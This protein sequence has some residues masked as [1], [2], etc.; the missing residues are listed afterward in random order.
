MMKDPYSEFIISHGP[1]NPVLSWYANDVEVY[2]QNIHFPESLTVN[3]RISPKQ[4]NEEAKYQHKPWD[5]PVLSVASPSKCQCCSYPLFTSHT[6]AYKPTLRQCF[7]TC[8]LQAAHNKAEMFSFKQAYSSPLGDSLSTEDHASVLGHAPWPH[9]WLRRCQVGFRNCCELMR[10]E[11]VSQFQFFFS[12]ASQ[13][14][15]KRLHSL[16]LSRNFTICHRKYCSLVFY[17][18]VAL[19]DLNSNL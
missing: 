3:N 8:D 2:P 5:Q 14:H 4:E 19:F 6:Y 9:L 1:R 7:S 15:L 18:F 16:I 17:Y 13:A 11:L 12:R 10:K